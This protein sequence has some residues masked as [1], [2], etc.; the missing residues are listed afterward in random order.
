MHQGI[1]QGED[2]S[3]KNGQWRAL[4]QSIE[5]PLKARHHKSHQHSHDSSS[6][7]NDRARIKHCRL[8]LAPELVGFLHEIGQ[9]AQ[10]DFQGASNLSGSHQVQIEGIENARVECTTA[11]ENELPFSIADERFPMTRLK[12]LFFLPALPGFASCGSETNPRRS[13]LRAAG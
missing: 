3:R 9:A 13:L 11:S 6:H 1:T 12:L 7:D 4:E 5:N 10:G 8:E 2:K